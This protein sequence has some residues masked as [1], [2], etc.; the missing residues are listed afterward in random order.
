VTFYK[1]LGMNK[2][3]RID[4]GLGAIGICILGSCVGIKE[5]TGMAIAEQLSQPLRSQIQIVTQ[6]INQALYGLGLPKTAGTGGSV[7][8]M[9]GSGG[10]FE[11]S[12]VKILP[13]LALMVPEDGAK[14]A[15][16]RPTVYWN[17]ILNKT[18][19]YRLTFFLQETAEET[20]KVVLEREIVVTKGGLYR[21]QIPQAVDT[22]TPR[23]WGVRCKWVSGR[24]EVANGLI[25]VIEPKPEVKVALDAA[26]SDLDKARVYATNG[27]W[28]DALNAYTNWIENNPQDAKAIQERGDVIKEG[29]KGHKGLD[30][31]SFVAQ[32]NSAAIQE[33][34]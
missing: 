30:T 32:V 17:A 1:S 4:I 11:S 3:L 2:V 20:S 21:F 13:I 34:K 9:D 14:S 5:I 8:I 28:Y 19:D 16:D 24:V 15:S 18:E 25:S 26:K 7:R 10:G 12:N 31:T 22:N 23:R 33:F 29:F 6:R 27:Y